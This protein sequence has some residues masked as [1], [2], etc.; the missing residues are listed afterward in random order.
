[1][2]LI[3]RLSPIEQ[4]LLGCSLL[5]VIFSFLDWQQV[6]ATGGGV[7]V[8]GGAS[9]W[10]GV[11]VVAALLGVAVLGWEVSRRLGAA[12]QLGSVSPELV[13][14]G[15]ALLLA[16]FTVITF[17]AHNEFR[18]WPSWIGLLLSIVIGVTAL[19]RGRAERVGMPSH[20]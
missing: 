13:S 17:L 12:R 3:K 6:C 14:M 16:L 7:E 19:G 1:M 8:C 10:H 11:G 20:A 15:L 5:Y 4:V 9:E 18:H 2:D